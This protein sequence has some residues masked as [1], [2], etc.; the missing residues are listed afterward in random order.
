MK[1]YRVLTDTF[2]KIPARGSVLHNAESGQVFIPQ[3]ENKIYLHW[4]RGDRLDATLTLKTTT[5]VS[6]QFEIVNNS[7]TAALIKLVKL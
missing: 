5:L 1:H 7:D 4:I 3:S 6:G 2:I